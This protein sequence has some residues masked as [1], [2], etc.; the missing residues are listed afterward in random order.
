MIRAA[1]RAVIVPVLSLLLVMVAACS[2]SDE[3]TDPTVGATS[4]IAP[5]TDVAVTLSKDGCTYEGSDS[6]PSGQ[7]AVQVINETDK[8][9]YAALLSIS[10]GYTFDDLVTWV[11]GPEARTGPPDWVTTIADGESRTWSDGGLNARLLPGRYAI[12][13]ADPKAPSGEIWAVGPFTVTG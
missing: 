3:P 2:R 9:L 1:D 8:L 4:T 10:D 12:V 6:V 5:P 13:C 11:G 7:V